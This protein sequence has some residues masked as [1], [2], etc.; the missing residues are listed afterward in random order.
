VL[1]ARG[2]QVFRRLARWSDVHA[3]WRLVRFQLDARRLGAAALPAQE[4]QL[5]AQAR[6]QLQVLHGLVWAPL[7]DAL[8]DARR[9]LLMPCAGL[10]G[11]PFAALQ[12]G[13]TCLAQRHLLAEVP[14]LSLA[15]KGL[16]S[17]APPAPTAPMAG[18]LH[19]PGVVLLGWGDGGLRGA[20]P[21]AQ[22]VGHS[23]DPAPAPTA[24]R[25]AARVQALLAGGGGARVLVRRWPVHDAVTTAFLHRFQQERRLG[26]GPT[27]ALSEAQAGL[28]VN[29][30]HPACWAGFVLCGGW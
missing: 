13:L 26:R 9:V 22:P 11:L 23:P 20:S 7:A 1:R 21:A 18:G 19:D 15:L 12:D 28:M 16:R 8:T 2:V 6:T 10:A 17:P 3:A 30:P 27:E 4:A 25:Q 29:R 24:A 14:N 5:L